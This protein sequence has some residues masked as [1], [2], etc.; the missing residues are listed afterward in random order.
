MN[1]VQADVIIT[2]AGLA[3]LT[4]ARQLLLYTDKTVLILD[5]L[6]NVPGKSM[7]VGESLVQLGGYYLYRTLD[8][9]EHLLT[10]HFL[11][12]NL[13]F[14]WKTTSGRH[15]YWED[16]SSSAIRTISNIATFQV[17]RNLLEDYLMKLNLEN[18]RFKFIGGAKNIKVDL[19]TNGVPTRSPG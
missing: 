6:A 19:A 18:P 10:E 5:K 15:D 4:L 9:E 14:H 8:L 13:R 12:Y 17:D 16:V 7:K 1:P 2:G 3:G 11:K